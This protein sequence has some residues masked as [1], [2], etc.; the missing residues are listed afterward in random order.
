MKNDILHM[1]PP[2]NYGRIIEEVADIFRDPAK[3]LLMLNKGIKEYHKIAR[4][5]KLCTPLVEAALRKFM[6]DEALKASPEHWDKILMLMENGELH[7]PNML[8]SRLYQFRHMAIIFLLVVFFSVIYPTFGL[9]RTTTDQTEAKLME[10]GK[11]TQAT[12]AA[13]NSDVV[14]GGKALEATAAESAVTARIP[15]GR[16]AEL[17]K[18]EKPRPVSINDDIAVSLYSPGTEVKGMERLEIKRKSP[19]LRKK[20]DMH[21]F[22]QSALT[23][24]F[25]LGVNR[26]VVDPGHG[27]I[28]IGAK[29]QCE[30]VVEKNVTL[31]LSL[32]LSEK[33]ARA[34]DCEV[35]MTRKTDVYLTLDERT[36][37]AN[38][39]NADL[40]I[41]VHT[42]ASKKPGS[43]GIET[44][45][46]NLATDDEAI[47]LAA[48]ENAEHAKTISDLYWLLNDLM[49]NAKISE[50]KRLAEHV[51]NYIITDMTARYD[52]IKDKG[53]RQAPFYVLL[54]AVMPA[55]LIE[56]AF[57]SNPREC[58]R[59]IDPEYQDI[60]TD[61]ITKG[62]VSYINEIH[63]TNNTL[64][65][66]E[67][68]RK[69]AETVK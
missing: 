36:G 66:K 51:Q 1:L 13:D 38:D 14:K 29:G 27:G 32:S 58:K 5:Y 43:F 19:E 63:P 10:T 46:L 61:A 41:S 45:Y 52:N 64:V 4:V 23:R 17:E 26:I 6:L 30:D 34:L 20:K 3:K 42:N 50:S 18:T 47:L 24:Q 48:R 2:D 67:S 33:L 53:V 28:D 12:L 39:V 31:A 11:N 55:I 54:E 68:D 40:F 35:I 59:L 65:I 22:T 37:L 21:I 44:Y 57:I 69:Q 56:T 49:Q 62:V 15:D 7:K 60:L 9:F 25:A 16:A 8:L